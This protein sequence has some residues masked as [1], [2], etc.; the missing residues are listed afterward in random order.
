MIK[1]KTLYI[2]IMFSNRVLFYKTY[3]TMLKE[4]IYLFCIGVGLWKLIEKYQ[5]TFR[6]LFLHSKLFPFILLWLPFFKVCMM[7]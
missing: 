4:F 6:L 2:K 1:N 7:E 5:P 3:R